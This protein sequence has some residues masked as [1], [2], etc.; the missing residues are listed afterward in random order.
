[1]RGLRPI[2]CRRTS[3]ELGR[4]FVSVQDG[5]LE[6]IEA[7][8]LDLIEAWE[9]YCKGRE[10]DDELIRESLLFLLDDKK[11]AD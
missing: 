2:D 9:G 6:L 11:K 4:E 8:T 5:S 7:W 3:L 1:M 10:F